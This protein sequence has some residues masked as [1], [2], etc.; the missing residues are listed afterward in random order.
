MSLRYLGTDNTY[1]MTMMFFA[2][3]CHTFL[4]LIKVKYLHEIY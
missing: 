3:N 1:S 4:V 2:S